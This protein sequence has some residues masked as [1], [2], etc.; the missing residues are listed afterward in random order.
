MSVKKINQK[1]QWYRDISALHKGKTFA[2]NT[3]IT[4]RSLAYWNKV[5]CHICK[6]SDSLLANTASTPHLTCPVQENYPFYSSKWPASGHRIMP[7]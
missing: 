3:G 5:T 1:V 4:S 2:G 7:M 6:I